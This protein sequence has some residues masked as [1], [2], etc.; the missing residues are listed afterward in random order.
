M[1]ETRY[2]TNCEKVTIHDVEV[3]RDAE[4]PPE[5]FIEAAHEGYAS[6]ADCSFYANGDSEYR[7]TCSVCFRYDIEV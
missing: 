5:S 6:S 1:K 7:F 2:C 4:N 3:E